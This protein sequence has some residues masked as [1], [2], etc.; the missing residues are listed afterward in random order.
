MYLCD[1][2]LTS[3]LSFTGIS[4]TS[5]SLLL[6]MIGFPTTSTTESMGLIVP[7]TKTS[8]PFGLI[9]LT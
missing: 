9:N 7:L 2:Q 5:T 1:E 4:T 6:Y 3:S 8:C